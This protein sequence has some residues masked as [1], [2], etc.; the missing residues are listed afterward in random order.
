MALP[1]KILNA[2]RAG[3]YVP[4]NASKKAREAA[5]RLQEQRNRGSSGVETGLPSGQ[6]RDTFR[7]VKREMVRRKHDAYYGIHNYNPSESSR[8]VYGSDEFQAMKRTLN[9]STEQMTR[10]AR[11]A[12]LAHNAVV[13]TGDAGELEIYLKYDFLFYHL[14]IPE[15]NGVRKCAQREEAP[16]QEF[17]I[18]RGRRR[19][20]RVR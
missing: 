18:H 12:S 17:R 11:L 13:N 8:A 10:L 14:S 4:S 9:L 6:P 19:G 5:T 1:R 7:S 16:I 3:Q 2:L 20:C 15:R